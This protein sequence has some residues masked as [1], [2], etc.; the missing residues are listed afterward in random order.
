M[1]SWVLIAVYVVL[2]IPILAILLFLGRLLWLLLLQGMKLE[3]K[4]EASWTADQSLLTLHLRARHTWRTIDITSIAMDREFAARLR[5]LPPAGFREASPTLPKREDFEP[6]MQDELIEKA[7]RGEISE[8]ELDRQFEAQFAEA[9]R[10]TKSYYD[11]NVIW[12]GRFPV[13]PFRKN[14]LLISINP[15]PETKGQIV[16][17]YLIKQGVL[18]QMQA[19]SSVHVD[20][21]L[22]T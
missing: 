2:A 10:D 4:V 17:S 11:S 16:F 6:D 3:P 22:R 7:D 9:V 20:F 18:V 8:E 5:P 13:K 12:T 21:P 15:Q 19:G 14:R 1:V